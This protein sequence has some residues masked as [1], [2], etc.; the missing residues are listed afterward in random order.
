[1]VSLNYRTSIAHHDWFSL[2]ARGHQV[3]YKQYHTSELIQATIL[4]PSTQGEEFVRLKYTRNGRDYENPSAPL[5]CSHPYHHRRMRHRSP[6][7][8]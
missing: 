6:R 7:L 2:L 4:G 5:S 3:L 8:P 1:M